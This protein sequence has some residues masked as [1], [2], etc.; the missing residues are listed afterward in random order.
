[1]WVGGAGLN[2]SNETVA[3]IEPPLRV[4]GHS[5]DTTGYLVYGARRHGK[6]RRAEPQ[7]GE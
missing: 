7:T 5:C 2:T 6:V 4:H 1:M 3:E